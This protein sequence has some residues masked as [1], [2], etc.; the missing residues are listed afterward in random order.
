MAY[1][2]AEFCPWRDGEVDELGI[3]AWERPNGPRLPWRRAQRD[4]ARVADVSLRAVHADLDGSDRAAW[5]AFGV[6]AGLRREDLYSF[7]SL[8]WD[9]ICVS[10]DQWTNGRHRA[11]AMQRAGATQ[12]AVVDPEWMPDWPVDVEVLR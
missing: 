1:A 4:W 8:A 12:V 6:R 3:G 5:R 9:P 7:E 11:Y 2:T 10:L